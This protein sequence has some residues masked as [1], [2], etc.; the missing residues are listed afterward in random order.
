MESTRG[1]LEPDEARRHF[2][3]TRSAP[4]ADLA[5]LVDCH[6]IVEWD[7]RGRPPFVQA[8]VTFPAVNLGIETRFAGLWGVVTQRSDHELTG[9]GKVVGTKFRPGGFHPFLPVDMATITDRILPLPEA[10]GTAADGLH[11]A[12]LD[13]GEDRAQIATVEAFLRGCDPQPDPSIALVGELVDRMLQ[14]PA[15][16]RVADV[17]RDAG[18]SS[19]TLQ[20]LFRR[21]VGVGPKWVLRRWRLHEAAER[22]AAGEVDDWARLALDLG[23]WDQAHFVNEFTAVIGRSPTAYAAATARQ[24]AAAA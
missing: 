8:I 18:L 14:A 9:R 7:L 10:F 3:L 24:A 19:R 16:V 21:Y 13:A 4:A 20:R 2:R 1:I 22:I 6:W 5:H 17:C 23:Y 11:E 15:T 12:V